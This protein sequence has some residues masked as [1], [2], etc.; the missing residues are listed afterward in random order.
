MSFADSVSP[1]DEKGSKPTK[2]ATMIAACDPILQ[3]VH[4]N[5]LGL[6][7][8]KA[9]HESVSGL[10]TRAEEMAGPL[11]LDDAIDSGLFG[12]LVVIFV[13]CYS[14]VVDKNGGLDDVWAQCDER[15][16][17]VYG[18]ASYVAD[19]VGIETPKI[20]T[21]AP[22]QEPKLEDK[23]E[24][25]KQEDKEDKSKDDSDDDDGNPMSFFA[26]G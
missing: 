16:A 15:L 9:F 25:A 5:D 11:G 14:N 4:V 18:L 19:K 10:K 2:I 26:A 8:D 12:S 7:A 23:P 17:M 24:A 21:P 1:T 20:A 3:A 6:G 13:A 22:S